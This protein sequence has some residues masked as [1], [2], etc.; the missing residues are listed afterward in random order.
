MNSNVFF[1]VSCLGRAYQVISQP[2]MSRKTGMISS[3]SL[4]LRGSGIGDASAYFSAMSNYGFTILA[5][6]QIKKIGDVFEG[7]AIIPEVNI[8]ITHEVINDIYLESILMQ[9]QGHVKVRFEIPLQ[10]VS[11]CLD[12][13]SITSGIDMINKYNGEVWLDYC[14]EMVSLISIINSFPWSGVKIDKSLLWRGEYTK[15][16]NIVN[17]CHSKSM[18]VIIDGIESEEQYK[19]ALKTG[20]DYLQGFYWPSVKIND[21]NMIID[22]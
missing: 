20:A 21:L 13:L 5:C 1:E 17:Y 6:E 8:K 10:K 9:Y 16:T 11:L 4:L 3:L 12:R 15:I 19:L 2:I 22:R 7:A 14:D 18:Q